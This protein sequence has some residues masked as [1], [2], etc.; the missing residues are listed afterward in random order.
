MLAKLRPRSA[1]DVMA[2]LSL[3]LVVAGGSAYATHELILS[4]DIVDGEVKTPDIA[5]AAVVTDK[6]AQAAVT[7]G[8][9]KNDNLTGGD[10]LDESL[11]GL[12]VADNSLKGADVDEA[13][14]DQVPAAVLGGKGRSAGGNGFACDPETETFVDCGFVRLDIPAQNRARGT[15]VLV[16]GAIT[17]FIELNFEEEG[18]G[19]CRLHTSPP[20]GPSTPLLQTETGFV[21]SDEDLGDYMESA[22]M[23]AVTPPLGPGTVDFGIECAEFNSGLD[24]V[25]AKI[26][27]VAISPN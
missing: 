14:L 5:N 19:G 15:R 23:T 16:T 21:V 24:F 22:A 4:S 26:A 20:G 2:V 13:T 1:Y 25:R 11:A 9:V 10:I 27:A 18:Q 8:K 17:G 3:F 12:D 6:I 7:S